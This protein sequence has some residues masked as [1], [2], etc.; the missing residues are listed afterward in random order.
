MIAIAPITSLPTTLRLLPDLPGTESGVDLYTPQLLRD[1]VA[2]FR[3]L[4]AVLAETADILRWGTLAAHHVTLTSAAL[5][6]A[7]WPLQD[8]RAINPVRTRL[9]EALEP[10]YLAAMALHDA[11]RHA[12]DLRLVGTE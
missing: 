2:E 4:V 10:T 8:R 3:T 1:N 11:A 6:S 9:R 7:R 12:K 5:R